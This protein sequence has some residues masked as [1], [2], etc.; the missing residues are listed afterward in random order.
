MTEDHLLYGPEREQY[1]LMVIDQLKTRGSKNCKSISQTAELQDNAA[2]TTE[3]SCNQTPHLE[4]TPIGNPRQPPHQSQKLKSDQVTTADNSGSSTMNSEPNTTPSQVYGAEHLL[5][6]FVKFPLFLCH[7]QLP[8]THIQLLY[9]LF[10]ELLTY[11][12]NR[13]NELFSEDNY[14]YESHEQGNTSGP[15]EP[16]GDGEMVEK[17][18]TCSSEPHDDIEGGEAPPTNVT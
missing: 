14:Y 11:L 4:H 15:L 9:H 3:N 2:T 18:R 5:R 8:A 12:C 10:K 16:E 1:R 7:A 6:L 17:Q 13:Q